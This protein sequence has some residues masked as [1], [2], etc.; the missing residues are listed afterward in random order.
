MV[1]D[2]ALAEYLD[3]EFAERFA[4]ALRE[5]GVAHVAVVPS[6]TRPDAWLTLVHPSDRALAERVRDERQKG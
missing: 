6:D 1:D 3:R 4:A 5:R 2:N